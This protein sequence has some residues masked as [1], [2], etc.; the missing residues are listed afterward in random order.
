MPKKSFCPPKLNPLVTGL[1][2]LFYPYILKRFLKG[3][4]VEIA[5]DQ[6]EKLR[7]LKYERLLILPNHPTGEDPYVIFELSTRLGVNFNYV[8]AREIFNWAKGFQGWVMQ[9]CGSYSLIRGKTDRESFS[10]T[11]NL[12]VE[13]ER[14]LTIFIEGEISNDNDT[15]LPFEPGVIQLAYWALDTIKKADKIESPEELPDVYALPVAIRY[16]YEDG[17]REAIAK[18]IHNLEVATGLEKE[19][20]VP[21]LYNKDIPLKEQFYARLQA[22]GDSILDFQEATLFLENSSDKPLNDRIDKIKNRLLEHMERFLELSAKEEESF[23]QRVRNVRNRMDE[24]IHAYGSEEELHGYEKRMTEHYSDIFSGFY[25]DLT[26]LV[27]FYTFQAG[28]VTE[29]DNIEGYVSLVHR[30]EKEVFGHAVLKHPRVAIVHIGDAV[31]LKENYKEYTGNKKAVIEEVTDQLEEQ[32]AE[33][34]AKTAG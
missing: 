5:P 3:L 29:S 8:A 6:L 2:R 26:R 1:V 7:A 12:I 14:P 20:S 30:L 16:R 28:R 19:G 23:L 25:Q 33:M 15:V 10:T 13:G 9:R 17:I 27:N 31:N 22:I 4:S 11:R 34:L 18:S 32:M 21:A 24:L